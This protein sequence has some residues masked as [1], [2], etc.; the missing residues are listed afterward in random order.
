MTIFD[1]KIGELERWNSG[2]VLSH[3]HLNG[4]VDAITAQRRIIT[5]PHQVRPEKPYAFTRQMKLVSIHGDYL[6]C[7]PWD[8]ATESDRELLVA[9]PYLLRRTPFDGETRNGIDYDYHTHVTRTATKGGETEDQIV[10]PRYVTGDI[11]Y[12]TFNVAGGTSVLDTE[13]RVEWLDDNRDGRALSQEF[14]A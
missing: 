8:G 10:I 11:L 5:P 4:P 9:K 7:H 3:Q 13:T 2:D 6:I 1:K 14:G 12:A